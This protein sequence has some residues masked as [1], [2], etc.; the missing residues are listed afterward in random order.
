M[1]LKF[2]SGHTEAGSQHPFLLLFFLSRSG[3][4]RRRTRNWE[5][6][7]RATRRGGAGVRASLRIAS[8]RAALPRVASHRLASPRPAS[9][10]IAS[11]RLSSP[12]VASHRLAS[13]RI[14]SRRLA[15]RRVAC[16]RSR[17]YRRIFN[18]IVSA[19][20]LLLSSNQMRTV[21]G[22]RPEM[23]QVVTS[24]EHLGLSTR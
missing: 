10:L 15:S 7:C 22:E 8:P 6:V 2:A 13:P 19:S 18:P 3:W 21:Q 14:A 20:H 12:C 1:T 17:R 5:D 23:F 16:N 11:H 4:S 24:A 9:P